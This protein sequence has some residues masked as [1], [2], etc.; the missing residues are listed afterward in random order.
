MKILYFAHL[1]EITGIPDETLNI[2]KLDQLYSHL[3]SK[4]PKM[5]LS[6]CLISLNCNIIPSTFD[7][8]IM[9]DDELVFIPPVSGG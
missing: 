5:N 2:S 4:Y 6:N 7:G 9:E 3:Q 8:D 1:K